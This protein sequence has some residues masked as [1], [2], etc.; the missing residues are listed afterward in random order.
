MAEPHAAP[1]DVVAIMKEIRESIQKKR[2]R[3]RLHGRRGRVAGRAAPARLRRGSED[4]RQAARAA[5]RAQPRLEHQRRL[6]DPHDAH[7]PGRAGAHPGQEG[8]SAPSSGCTPTTSSTGRRSSTSTSPTSCTTTS[9]RARACSSRCRGSAIAWRSWRGSWSCAAAIPWT[10]GRAAPRR[11]RR[12]CVEARARRPALRRGGD[13]RGRAAR[14]LDRAAPGPR[15]HQVQVLT[16]C[17]VDYLTWENKYEPG[18]STVGGLPVLRVPGGAPAHDRGLRRPLLQGPLLRAQ[19]RRGAA[20]DGGARAGDAR[21][22]SSTCERHGGD[23]D[24]LVF[25]SYRYWT[26]YHGLRVAPAQEHP[27]PHRG[28]GRRGAPAHLQGLLP[29]SR[30]PTPSTRPRRRTCCCA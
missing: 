5:A 11:A 3:G 22:S 6:P 14:A 30:P 20:L 25:F 13:R 18:A 27:R 26:T 10:A 29:P 21:T 17:A 1:V 15:C 16:T 19:R 7:R 2:A 12:R 8:S 23:Y 28:R 4:R 9:A 24:A